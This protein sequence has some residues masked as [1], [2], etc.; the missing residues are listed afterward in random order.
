LKNLECLVS[1]LQDPRGFLEQYKKG[2]AI[3]DE[4]QRVPE[5]FSYLQQVLDENPQKG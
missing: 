4:V 5:L 2:G 1:A 3:L